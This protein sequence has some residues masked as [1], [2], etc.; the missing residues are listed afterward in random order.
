MTTTT[1]KQ[2]WKEGDRV[3]CVAEFDHEKVS[4]RFEVIGTGF[5]FNFC[6][7]THEFIDTV[8]IGDFVWH[9]F[10]RLD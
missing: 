3:C 10:E 9:V 4:R 7:E 1:E 8:Q 5:P 2:L 6:H